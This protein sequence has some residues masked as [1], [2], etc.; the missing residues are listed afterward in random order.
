VP[1]QNRHTTLK[2]ICLLVS[3]VLYG[4]S[5]NQAWAF[6]PP[7]ASPGTCTPYCEKSMTDGNQLTTV[8]RRGKL[9]FNQAYMDLSS[10]IDA[11][12]QAIVKA[13]MG[14]DQN[15]TRRVIATEKNNKNMVDARVNANI[16]LTGNITKKAITEPMRPNAA[17][18]LQ[19]TNSNRLGH[20]NV[21]QTAYIATETGH[22]LATALPGIKASEDTSNG[23]SKDFLGPPS[24]KKI[25]ALNKLAGTTVQPIKTGLAGQCLASGLMRQLAASNRGFGIFTQTTSATG[26]S[27]GHSGGDFDL[28]VKDPKTGEKTKAGL[29]ID[30]LIRNPNTKDPNALAF[31]Q[32]LNEQQSIGSTLIQFEQVNAADKSKNITYRYIGGDFVAVKGNPNATGDHLHVGTAN[33]G[34]E[35]DVEKLLKDPNADLK[36]GYTC[37]DLERLTGKSIAELDRL[38]AAEAFRALQAGCKILQCVSPPGKCIGPNKTTNCCKCSRIS[39]GNALYSQSRD[40]RLYS[41][42]IDEYAN[43]TAGNSPSTVDETNAKLMDSQLNMAAFTGAIT[44]KA[45]D[46]V[47]LVRTIL[48]TDL[49]PLDANLN[50]E[51]VALDVNGRVAFN[52]NVRNTLLAILQGSLV[53]YMASY[54]MP[55]TDGGNKALETLVASLLPADGGTDG[56][57]QAVATMASGLIG[58]GNTLSM[59][60][61]SEIDVMHYTSASYQQ[62]LL[63]QPSKLQTQMLTILARQLREKFK[64]LHML[65]MI[66]LIKA[67]RVA[68]NA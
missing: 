20:A 26:P 44:T 8:K 7:P 1:R 64:R 10:A 61:Q 16:T 50:Q 66:N 36:L 40:A 54:Q 56:Q 33:A 30:E 28:R 9:S 6:C 45:H 57:R 65:Q 19:T 25:A 31:K 68:H 32:M 3:I 52:N 55:V 34:Y 5:T 27:K 11:A 23:E 49:L 14:A 47:R 12:E 35:K 17:D 43:N 24:A 21:T 63:N 39:S 51:S 38:T 37:A 22:T 58:K 2:L 60:A 18:C 15:K 41:K 42:I 4:S 29:A 46:N 53:T 13:I 62:S 67:I 59:S 48:S